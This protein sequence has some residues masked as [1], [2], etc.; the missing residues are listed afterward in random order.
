[1]VTVTDTIWFWLVFV[2]YLAMLAVFGVISKRK[3]KTITDWM[4]ASRGIG[5][6][7]LALSYGATYFSAVL[8]IGS[9]GNTWNAG[10]QWMWITLTN[11]IFGTFVA[12][13]LLGNRSRRMSMKLGALTLPELI[14][15]RY[16]DK[17]YI[18][19]TS[20][21]V[22]GV[23]LTVY[24]V[25]VFIGMSVL[26]VVLFPG[27]E[28]AFQIGVIVIGIVSVSYIVIGGSH[29]AILSD[30][31]ESMIM[32]VGVV[33]IVIGGLLAVGGIAGMNA[34]I[35]A[36]IA[37][38][39]ANGIAEPFLSDPA[40]W[41]LFP[42]LLSMPMIG[43]ALV[44]AFGTWG[45]PQM[46]TRFFTSKNRKAV[47]Y[48]LIIVCIWVAV[49][50]FCAW[51]SGAVA[52]GLA[53][54]STQQLQSWLQTSV[55]GA[56]MAKWTEYVIPWALTQSGYF[57]VWFAALFLASVLA[58]SLTTGEK[59]IIVASGS[60]TRDFWQKGVRRDKNISDETTLKWTKVF[61]G[62]IILAAIL[63]TLARPAFI[64]DLCMWAWSCLN[65]FTL[66]PF[67]AGLYWK[68]G[69]KRAA[70]IS[71]IIALVVSILWFFCFYPKW[72]PI[73]GVQ[74]FPLIPGIFTKLT[75]I[76]EFII[77][78]AV[79]IPA[80]FIISLLDRK[81]PDKTFLDDLFKYV[82]EDTND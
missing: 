56:D 6:V 41:F 29:G 55:P 44:T 80:F 10:E 16:Q 51:F 3:T 52:R 36:D 2:I 12:F 42:N 72:T 60:I 17:R 8:F 57:P 78:Q 53:P 64:L 28:Y 35:L 11:V 4:V 14:A 58:A 61:V 43:M 82:K 71:G 74:V 20:G 18:R 69:T 24:L 65:A 62:V 34:N 45:S 15:E 76:H 40:A 66:V 47:R 19:Q 63:L 73:G 38:N 49:V 77:S 9:P 30:L 13:L 25:S 26:L 48:G 23:F 81:K 79:A 54:D 27:F 21:L 75:Y 67:V 5:P 68:G 7:L 46:S 32:L 1:M 37:N 22:L 70:F 39:G 50:S 59:L 33:G 31:V